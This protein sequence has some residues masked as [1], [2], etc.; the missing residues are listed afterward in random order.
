MQIDGVGAAQPK[1]VGVAPK[2]LCPTPPPLPEYAF[3]MLVSSFIWLDRL[4]TSPSIPVTSS[5]EAALMFSLACFCSTANKSC[6][7]EYFTYPLLWLSPL[8]THCRKRHT[9]K[10]DEPRK[11][12]LCQM[13]E[14][15]R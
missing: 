1:G 9:N 11:E 4:V 15:G 5:V 13:P 2:S 10:G 8:K 3:T 12:D 7:S 14:H 6:F